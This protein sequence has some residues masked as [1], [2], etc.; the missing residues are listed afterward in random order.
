MFAIGFDKKR[1]KAEG[2]VYSAAT[3]VHIFLPAAGDYIYQG[4]ENNTRYWSATHNSRSL[5]YGSAVGFNYNYLETS[6]LYRCAGFPV[7]P[8][9]KP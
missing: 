3:D 2:H 6:N 7:R 5:R 1:T 8:V 9:I 4:V